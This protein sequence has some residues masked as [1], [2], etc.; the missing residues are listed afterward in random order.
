MSCATRPTPPCPCVP[1]DPERSASGAG[2]TRPTGQ[3]QGHDYRNFD[4]LADLRPVPGSPWFLV[5]KVDTDEILAEARY[6]AGMITLLVL[7]GILLA[8]AATAIAYRR[9][10][11]VSIAICT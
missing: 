7:M 4:V 1:A 10:R 3:F 5:T 2:G 8:A 9:G 6:R 11:S